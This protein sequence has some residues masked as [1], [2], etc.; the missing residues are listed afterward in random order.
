MCV[1]SETWKTDHGWK[2]LQL[3]AIAF[4]SCNSLGMD[5]SLE[6][7]PSI[8]GRSKMKPRNSNLFKHEA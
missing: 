4:C 3:W 7:W 6:C 1:D 8:S 2:V 5:C